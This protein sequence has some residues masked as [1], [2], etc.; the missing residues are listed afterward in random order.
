MKKEREGALVSIEAR[1]VDTMLLMVA[2][3]IA[4]LGH[5]SRAFRPLPNRR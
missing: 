1:D 2:T 4:T 5:L 3:R